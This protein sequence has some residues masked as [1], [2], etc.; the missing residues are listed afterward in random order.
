MVRSVFL[1]ADAQFA[2]AEC[3]P[4]AYAVSLAMAH[5]A[6][7]TLFVTC[8]DVT[9]PGAPPNAGAIA[10]GIAAAARAAGV[11]CHIVSEYSRALGIPEA[12]AQHARL[13]DLVVT[14]SVSGP[15]LTERQL[16]EFLA[17][18]AGRP[19]LIVP[20]NHT[21]PHSAEVVAAAWDDTPSA[22]RALGDAIDLL[23]PGE[24]LLLTI[25]GEKQLTPGLGDSELLDAC[26]RRGLHAR[27]I[28]AEKGSRS[29]ADALQNEAQCNGATLLAMGAFGHSRVR[30][31]VLGSA[32]D[33]VL[34]GPK[35]P[36]LLSH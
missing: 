8:L 18:E 33:G 24:V 25:S 5:G 7:L 30:R 20:H 36:I 16:A 32:T 3:G 13:H 27:L 1:F 9:T 31:F 34:T 6:H 19:V 22:A 28:S 14:G 29:I 2:S 15:I 4:A 11:A 17:F 21:A 23:A 35:L 26:A 10:E 12:V